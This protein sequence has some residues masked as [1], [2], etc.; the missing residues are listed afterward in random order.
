MGLSTEWAAHAGLLLMFALGLRHGLDPDH[1][2]CID[3]LTWRS[4]ESGG[5]L[6]RWVG[7]L[8]ALG[9]GL[10]VTLVAV[11]LGQLAVS[12]PIPPGIATIFDWLPTLLLVAVGVLNLRELLS[13]GRH[14]QV[15]GWISGL[16]PGRLRQRS[17]PLG[18]VL[19]GMLFAV[20]FDTATQ[21]S[22]WA[23]ATTVQGGS[24]AA[25]VA[26]LAFTLG[27]AMTD[28]IDGRLL[29]GAARRAGNSEGSGRHR[30]ALGMLIVCMSFGA[31]LYRIIAAFEPDAELD[32][33]TYSAIGLLLFL[34]MFAAWAWTFLARSEKRPAQRAAKIS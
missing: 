23:Y 4:I 17:G 22:M 21:A 25:M 16:I 33:L 10:V 2:A 24:M 20:V 9:H 28:T 34:V 11:L 6:A 7:T 18:V 3:S 8:F 30:R 14:Y 15:R 1:I 29:C 13:P 32:E 19:V 27:M 5:G 12:V 26:G 31:A